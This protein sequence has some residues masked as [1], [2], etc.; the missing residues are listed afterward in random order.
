MTTAQGYPAIA[1]LYFGT[2]PASGRTVTIGSTVYVF[3]SGGP[4]GAAPV[5]IGANVAEARANLVAAIAA[6]P[7]NVKSSLRGDFVRITNADA[8]GGNPVAGTQVLALASNFAGEG[9][10]WDRANLNES[11]EDHAKR[12]DGRI[13]V[14]ER[15]HTRGELRIFT[16]ID[17]AHAA[18]WAHR[19]RR[20][21][22][23]EAR[24]SV[25]TDG[26]DIVV[27]LRGILPGACVTWEAFGN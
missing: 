27:S 2:K 15:M 19:D 12:V 20:A 14:S 1:E 23:R 24:L 25:E 16:G 21:N 6:G 26:Q 9:E 8:P 4:Q 11:G 18:A 13:D 22:A 17:V 3:G 5:E 10:G 7:A